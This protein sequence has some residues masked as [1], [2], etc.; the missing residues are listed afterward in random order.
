MIL[1]YHM[2]NHIYHTI[3]VKR[4]HIHTKQLLLGQIMCDIII[5]YIKTIL[6]NNNFHLKIVYEKLF[7]YLQVN[8]FCDKIY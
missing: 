5:H 8:C 7:I 1:F 2:L 3:I 6:V 4:F